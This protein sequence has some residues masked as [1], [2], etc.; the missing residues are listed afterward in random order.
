MTEPEPPS[1]QDLSLNNNDAD[2]RTVGYTMLLLTVHGALGVTAFGLF[3]PLAA[4]ASRFRTNG[5]KMHPLLSCCSHWFRRHQTLGFGGCALA[6]AS[7]V[8]V[9]VHK[10][11][12]AHPHLLSSHSLW[13]AAAIT[14]A[15]AQVLSG[16]LRPPNST[17]PTEVRQYWRVAHTAAGVVTIVAGFAAS[18]LGLQMPMASGSPFL[19]LFVCWVALL[20]TLWL[21][22][23]AWRC[24]TWQEEDLQLAQD[25]SRESSATKWAARQGNEVWELPRLSISST[26]SNET[27]LGPACNEA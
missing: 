11:R 9:E 14:V 13:G 2:G 22:V 27:A 23:E 15:I 18:V 26:T 10:F 6:S 19:T 16:L 20:S 3:F 12:G 7:L 21:A 4:A 25:S 1:L 17:P 5:K 24:K 8:L